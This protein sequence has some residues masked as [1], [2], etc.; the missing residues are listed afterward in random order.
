VDLLGNVYIA[1]SSNNRVRKIDNSG[2][3]TT[4]AG[5]GVNGGAPDGVPATE[6]RL[7]TPVGLAF[8]AAGNLIVGHGG[9]GQIRRIAA[10]TQI[11]ETIAGRLTPGFS[12]DGGA[13]K[14]AQLNFPNQLAITPDGK[15]FVADRMNYRIRVLVPEAPSVE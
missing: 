1:D 14:D 11:I 12:G 6:S 8:D 13:A 9:G 4:I 3:I 5:T 10:D 15:I 2:V 7:N